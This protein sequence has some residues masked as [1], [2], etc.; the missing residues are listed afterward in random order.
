MPYPDHGEGL[1]GD[2][3]PGDL[4]IIYPKC[5]KLHEATTTTITSR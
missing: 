3:H 5:K 4:V 1:P 2:I